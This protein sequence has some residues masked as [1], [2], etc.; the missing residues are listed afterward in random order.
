MISNPCQVPITIKVQP[1]QIWARG[2][3]RYRITKLGH[4]KD[5][6]FCAFAKYI[7]K[8]EGVGASGPK[9]EIL[10][11]ELTA[12]GLPHCWDQGWTLE[13]MPS[14]ETRTETIQ[15][16]RSPEFLFF[17]ASSH[18][19]ACQKCGAPVPCA[20]HTILATY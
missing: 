15:E 2:E 8:A 14:T 20:Y 11:G 10:F 19:E 16:D 4:A 3:I 17:R 12:D 13:G 1:N 7:P 6:S 5:G 18:A 9:D